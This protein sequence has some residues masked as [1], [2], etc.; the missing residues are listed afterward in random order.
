MSFVAFALAYAGLAAF[1]LAMNRHARD[2][3]QRELAGRSRLT[4]RCAGCCLLVASLILTAAGSGWPMGTVEW[5][6]ML[7]AS[8]VACVLLLTYY[9]KA[10]AVLAAVLPALAVVAL[11]LGRYMAWPSP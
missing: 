7:I 2:V 8:A 4:L 10:V 1:S 11:I 9:P 5:F 3:F 6:G